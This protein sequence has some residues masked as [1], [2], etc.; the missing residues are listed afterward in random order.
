MRR[1]SYP[2]GR[3]LCV[4]TGGVV[5]LL[6]A[7]AAPGRALL[8]G[9]ASSLVFPRLAKSE[10]PVD[11]APGF[12]LAC[13]TL[14]PQPIA[15]PLVSPR[16]RAAGQLPQPLERRQNSSGAKQRSYKM[17]SPVYSTATWRPTKKTPADGGCAE[18]AGPLTAVAA[19]KSGWPTAVAAGCE[20]ELA[21]LGVVQPS[22]KRK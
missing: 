2:E 5:S 17:T 7:C 13:C 22:I 1:P 6:P 20:V 18:G 12:S 19:P 16:R 4:P 15:H 14:A 9:A 11:A 8:A 3:P 10:Q 21:E